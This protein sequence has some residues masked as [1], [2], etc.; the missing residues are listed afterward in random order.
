MQNDLII[1][2][3]EDLPGYIAIC[4]VCGAPSSRIDDG[5]NIKDKLQIRYAFLLY[6][7]SYY[8]GDCYDLTDT[9]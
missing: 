8:K 9:I 1:A 7:K 3:D 6:C 4:F 5:W 2:G